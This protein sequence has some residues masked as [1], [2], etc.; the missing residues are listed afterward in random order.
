MLSGLRLLDDDVLDST[1]A[2]KE[3]LDVVFVELER[4][5]DRDSKDAQVLLDGA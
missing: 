4:M 3:L 1:E 5:A 2:P